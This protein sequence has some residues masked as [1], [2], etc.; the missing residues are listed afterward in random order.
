MSMISVAADSMSLE[1]G[2]ADFSWKAVVL[3]CCVG[4]VVSFEL[5]ARGVDLTA[6]LI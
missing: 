2:S 5:M 1:A 3:F 4:L 6:G